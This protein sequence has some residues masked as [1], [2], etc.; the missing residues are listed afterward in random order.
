MGTEVKMCPIT[1]S[2][3]HSA[4]DKEEAR[5]LPV[6]ENRHTGMLIS[7]RRVLKKILNSGFKCRA[8]VFTRSTANYEDNQ[9]LSSWN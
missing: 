3:C 4:P 1:P 8:K 2:I 9:R 7:E 5:G 6:S